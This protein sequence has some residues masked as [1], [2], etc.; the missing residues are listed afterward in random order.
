MSRAKETVSEEPSTTA[1][2][3]PGK[4]K[5]PSHDVGENLTKSRDREPPKELLGEA[6]VGD[7]IRH[8][9]STLTA[10]H[11][12][13]YTKRYLG[14]LS[15]AELEGKYLPTRAFLDATGYETSRDLTSLPGF[16]EHITPG[17]ETELKRTVEEN[18]SP[19]TLLLTSSGIRAA[20]ITR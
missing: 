6:G 7:S 19:H 1:V 13:K 5:R 18:G 16:L 20:N 10:D 4:R 12:A 11:F 17:S 8:M 15:N 9:N 3:K 2:V 14:D